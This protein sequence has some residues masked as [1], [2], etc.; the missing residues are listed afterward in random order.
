MV[1]RILQKWT[2]EK[3]RCGSRDVTSEIHVEQTQTA[4][5]MLGIGVG[6]AAVTLT[7]EVWMQCSGDL[8]KKRLK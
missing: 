1:T 5:Y 3:K 8:K 7:V 6:L 2:P 4:F